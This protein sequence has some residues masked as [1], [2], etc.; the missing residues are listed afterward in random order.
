[1]IIQLRM[2]RELIKPSL[3]T[4]FLFLFLFLSFRLLKVARKDSDSTPFLPF[5]LHR[6]C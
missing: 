5:A 2:V 3:Y 6:E 1:M 4:G